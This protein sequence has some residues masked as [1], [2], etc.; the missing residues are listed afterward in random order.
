MKRDV[1]MACQKYTNKEGYKSEGKYT[2]PH[3]SL[4]LFTI[5]SEDVGTG[6]ADHKGTQRGRLGA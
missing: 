3:P 1:G 4:H 5:Y 6:L 2:K